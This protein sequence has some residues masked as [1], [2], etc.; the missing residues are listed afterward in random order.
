MQTKLTVLVIDDDPPIRTLLAYAFAS[1][2]IAVIAAADGIEAIAL[3]DR[4]R[5][6]AIIVDLQMP[7]MDGAA[8]M[9]ALA[10]RDE[11]PPVLLMSCLDARRSAQRLGA[12]ASVDKPFDPEAVVTQVEALIASV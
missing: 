5:P 6:D 2:G 1:H 8:F 7:I 4:A 9:Q 12:S 10:L 3:L 11:Q